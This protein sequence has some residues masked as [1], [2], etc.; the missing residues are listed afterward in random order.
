MGGSKFEVQ[1]EG[2]DKIFIYI[3]VQRD[4]Y[5]SSCRTFIYFITPVI[6]RHF[7]K[8]VR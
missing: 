6:N 8:S 1:A 5:G 2:K 4:L 3:H 7:V